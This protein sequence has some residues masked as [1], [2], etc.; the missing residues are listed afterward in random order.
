MTL[1]N[2][3]VRS[4]QVS[5]LAIGDPG[6]LRESVSSL[7]PAVPLSWLEVFYFFDV[8]VRLYVC[9][10]NRSRDCPDTVILAL[11][12]HFFRVSGW[13]EHS[14][15]LLPSLQAVCDV[16]LLVMQVCILKDVTSRPYMLIIAEIR[17]SFM[18]TIFCV[19]FRLCSPRLFLL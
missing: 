6:I 5:G 8:I 14:D 15:M 17:S 2:S 3:L 19:M 9:C 13:A 11:L 4:D 12:T 18:K 1:S 10:K 16:G 7:S